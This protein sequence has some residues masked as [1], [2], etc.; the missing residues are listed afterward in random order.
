MCPVPIRTEG[1]FNLDIEHLAYVKE[2]YYQSYDH[3]TE[4]IGELRE[5]IFMITPLTWSGN[6]ARAL[7]TNY[8]SY[9]NTHMDP[10]AIHLWQNGNAL[11]DAQIAAGNLKKYCEDFEELFASGQR[12]T[13]SLGNTFFSARSGKIFCDCLQVENVQKKCE[14]VIEDASAVNSVANRLEDCFSKLC[15]V[16]LS[17]GPFL[18]RIHEDCQTVRSR[19]ALYQESLGVYK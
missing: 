14:D 11:A 17:Y 10:C 6:D 5:I 18:N 8:N 3:L 4:Q 2:A 7:Q 9:I 1:Y 16:E 12:P 15:G 13:L 19:F